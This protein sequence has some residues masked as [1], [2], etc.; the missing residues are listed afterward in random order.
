MTHTKYVFCLRAKKIA[1]KIEKEDD[2]NGDELGGR[3]FDDASEIIYVNAS[4]QSDTEFGWL[5]H[6]FRC[7]NPEEMHYKVLAERARFFKTH[8][9][10][11]NTMCKIMEEIK[12]KGAVEATR[13]IICNFLASKKL[14][15]EEIAAGT[16]T[17]VEEVARIAKENGLAY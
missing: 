3:R 12:E 16:N 7:M 6:D 15:Y 2:A 8:E 4:Y 5:M 11:V 1:C 10:G 9:S 17:T 14:S 13:N